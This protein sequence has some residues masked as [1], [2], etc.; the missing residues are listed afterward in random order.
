MLLK[1]TQAYGSFGIAWLT[2]LTALIFCHHSFG[3][4]LFHEDFSVTDLDS[5]MWETSTAS[6]ASV[7]DNMFVFK[8]AGT[9]PAPE[10]YQQIQQGS[11]KGTRWDYLIARQSFPAT[12]GGKVQ[13]LTLKV[14]LS[15]NAYFITGLL[16]D[17]KYADG[18]VMNSALQ[19][20]FHG[21]RL[22]RALWFMQGPQ[23]THPD[24]SV[25]QAGRLLRL[26]DPPV[27]CQTYKIRLEL[28]STGGALWQYDFGNGWKT[29]RDTRG[30]GDGD[31]MDAC[32][33][34]ITADFYGD[35]ELRVDDVTVELIDPTPRQAVDQPRWD[36]PVNAE[37]DGKMD[38]GWTNWAGELGVWWA[39]LSRAD[40]QTNPGWLTLQGPAGGFGLH[41]RHYPF[42]SSKPHPFLVEIHLRYPTV[43]PPEANYM[44][45]ASLQLDVDGDLM[46]DDIAYPSFVIQH[47]HEKKV[48]QM[49]VQTM[50]AAGQDAFIQCS[51]S[52]TDLPEHWQAGVVYLRVGLVSGNTLEFSYRFDAKDP[53]TAFYTFHTDSTML[54]RPIG[55]D[56][57]GPCANSNWGMPPPPQC[58]AEEV[59]FEID[60][61]RFM[62]RVE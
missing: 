13:R 8:L 43:N 9:P 26:S 4:T 5:E 16:P 37:F 46:T 40:F 51:K 6:S 12:S 33:F 27:A 30:N 53:W 61:V 62:D 22:D 47:L 41:L 3:Q 14:A 45:M 25:P 36:S 7:Q 15:P 32:R 39:T 54:G 48:T 18:Q 24:P 19:Y 58:K 11:A 29:G 34:F 21:N 44:I 60:Y 28:G 50:A 38:A 57:I 1:N 31:L 59:S 42:L 20:G 10:Y 23:L 55:F 17:G 35:G 56:L 52:D 49:R 2:V